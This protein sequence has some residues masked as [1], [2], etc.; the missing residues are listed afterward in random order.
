MGPQLEGGPS[1][2]DRAYGGVYN[3]NSPRP[4][5]SERYH[6]T[7]DHDQS[8]GGRTPTN[9]NP[10]GSLDRLNAPAPADPNARKLSEGR[11]SGERNRSRTRTGRTGSGQL[12]ICRKCMEPLT[13][14]F[15][16]ALGGTFHLD[17]FRCKVHLSCA[18]DWPID[19]C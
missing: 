14:Q 4:S 5:D 2:D 3:G 11:K 19:P 7:Q 1:N 13:G 6:Q 15:V 12:R 10:N 8:Q 9:P 16:R 18:K 17:C